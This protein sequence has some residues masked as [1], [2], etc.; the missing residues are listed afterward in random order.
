LILFDEKL[1]DKLDKKYHVAILN[2]KTHK[3]IG[4]SSPQIQKFL[5]QAFCSREQNTNMEKQ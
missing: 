1:D 3:I 4:G 2:P 5:F